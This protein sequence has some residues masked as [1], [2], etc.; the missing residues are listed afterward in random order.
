MNISTAPAPVLRGITVYPI[1]ALDGVKCERIDVNPGG[2]LAADRRFALVDSGNGFIN[3]KRYPRVNQIRARYSA[4]L[5]HVYLS[6]SGL[7]GGE[8]CFELSE[9]N[10]AL[11]EWL[12]DALGMKVVLEQ[13]SANGFPD[14]HNSPGPTL[15]SAASCARVREW[16]PDIDASAIRRRFRANLEIDG[17]PAF[18][19]DRL[20]LGPKHAF[21]I[22][23]VGFVA[24]KLCNRC[25]VPTLDPDTGVADANFQARFISHRAALLPAGVNPYT[26]SIK[27]R[28]A[29]ATSGRLQVGMRL[30]TV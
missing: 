2:A 5:R 13:D 15:I 19:E 22:G 3:G 23:G 17:V 12:G 11:S 14:S 28:L 24:T 16:F 9:R 10:A 18:W 29:A 26:L 27:T 30:H 8:D 4:D 7:A 6:L 21:T 1:K 25:Q 20:A